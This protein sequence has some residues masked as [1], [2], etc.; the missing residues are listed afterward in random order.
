V[1]QAQAALQRL[2][3]APINY[4]RGAAGIGLGTTIK[5]LAQCLCVEPK[6]AF[7]N[8]MLHAGV[9]RPHTGFVESP[10]FISPIKKFYFLNKH[11]FELNR[12]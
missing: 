8:S 7:C 6:L 5:Y 10:F 9:L 11:D 3:H 12:A 1:P 4:L 2:K